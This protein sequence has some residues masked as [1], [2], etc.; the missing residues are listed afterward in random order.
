MIAWHSMLL[1]QSSQAADVEK[2]R[3]IERPCGRLEWVEEVPVKGKPA[4]SE[5]KSRPIKKAKISLLP[6]ENESFCRG[7]GAPVAR[8]VTKANGHFEFKH[9]V[10]G[11]YWVA[12]ELAG[13]QL[14]VAV[15]YVPSKEEVSCSSLLYDV[16]KGE[17]QL[18]RMIE[19]D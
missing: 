19:V 7:D 16:I 6:R 1:G 8:T 18:R 12:V 4:E 13:K 15:N 11:K 17:L 5:E 14:A 3:T 2:W 9:V 10:P